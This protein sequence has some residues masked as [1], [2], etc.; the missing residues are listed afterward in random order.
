MSWT[1]VIAAGV[2][3]GVVYTLSPLTVLCAAGLIAIMKGTARDLSGRERDWFYILF[4]LAIVLRFAVIAALM[5]SADGSRPYTAFFGDEWIFKSRPIWLR[6]VGLDIPISSADFIYTFDPTGNSGHLYVLALLQALVGDAP[7]GAHVFNAT[8]YV[9][10]I[11]VLFRMVRRSFGPGVAWGGSAVLLFLPSLFA[12]SV[13]VL[14]E[15]LYTAGAVA[16]LLLVIAVVRSPR[17]WQRGLAVSAVVIL[18]FAM[19]QLRVGTFVVFGFGAAAGLMA[20]WI[21]ATRRRT[22]AAAIL[23][24]I[25]A[26]VAIVLEPVQA[27][28]LSQLRFVARYHV[29]HVMTPGVSYKIVDPRYYGTRRMEIDHISRRE[30]LQYAVRSMIAYVI[31]PTPANMQSRLLWLYLPEHIAWLILFA[32]AP[33]GFVAGLSR[34]RLLTAMLAAHAVANILIVAMT[35]G[36]IGTLIRHRGLSL[37]FLVWLSMLGGAALFAR[38]AARD[39]HR[40]GEL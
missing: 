33:I 7:Y 9:A 22:V 38:I 11:A 40:M 23:L 16:E 5:L 12:W 3:L 30:A 20:Y 28:V 2:A 34:D 14:K 29:G 39:H 10:A 35:S 13:S 36:N 37:P 1:W 21:L 8:V 6:N 31:E 17:W 15:P 19:E 25:A 26:I 27:R 4:I 18:A 24:P 32:L